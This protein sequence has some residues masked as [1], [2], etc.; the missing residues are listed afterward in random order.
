MLY[1]DPV[2]FF[3]APG[4]PLAS[5]AIVR[6]EDLYGE[7]LIAKFAELFWGQIH[8]DLARR[9]YTWPNQIDLRSSEAIKRIVEGGMGI[10]VLF[11]SS[12]A[13][14]F[15]DGRLVRLPVADAM[16]LQTFCI[17]RRPEIVQTPLARELCDYLRAAFADGVTV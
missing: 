3:A 11:A 15:A 13:A 17:L 5:R 1:D 6:L 9:G 10:G 8:H 4:S 14:E 2:V 16:L 12:V 7:T